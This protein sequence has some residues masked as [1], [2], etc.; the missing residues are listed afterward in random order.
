METIDNSTISAEKQQLN[1][2]LMEK[3][4]PIA[5]IGI[6]LR[7]PGNNLTSDDF[8]Q[9]L[10]NKG[11]GIVDIPVDRWNNKEFYQNSPERG[12]IKTNKGGYLNNITD[13]DAKFFNISPKEAHYIDPQ[14]RIVLESSWEALENANVNIEALKGSDGGV[15]MGVSSIDYSLEVVSLPNDELAAPIGTGTSHS[16]VAGRISYFLGWKGPSVSVDTACSSSLVALHQATQALRR[17]ECSIALCGGVN[18]IHHPRNL[19]IFS[20]ANMLSADGRC[21]TFDDTADGYGRSEGCSVVV[22]KR[23]SDAM[24]DGDHIYATV[25]GSAVNQDGESGGLTVPNGIAQE[26]TMR[27]ALKDAALFPEDIDFVEAHGTGTS[28]GDPIEVNAINNVF[29]QSHSKQ[30][31]LYI[32]SVKGNIG[33]TE[34]AAGIVGVVKA[35]L[36][37]NHA[38]IYSHISMHTPSTHIPWQQYI[39]EVPLESKPMQPKVNRG[40]VNSFGF[41]GTLSSIVLEQAPK[42]RVDNNNQ[43]AADNKQTTQYPTPI[44]CVSAKSK[45][46]LSNQLSRLKNYMENNPTIDLSALA[47][48]TNQRTHFNQRLSYPVNV[49]ALQSPEKNTEVLNWLSKQIEKLAEGKFQESSSPKVAL[50]FTGQGSQY[51]GMGAE[52]YLVSPIFRAA[53]DLCDRMFTPYLQT[54]IKAIMFGEDGE[55]AQKI[56]QTL[57]TQTSLFTFEYAMSRYWFSLGIQPSCVIGHSIGE[58]VAACVAGML[59]LENA[60]KLVANRAML[61][62]SVKAQGGMLAVKATESQLQNYLS[63]FPAL[64]FAAINSPQQCVISGEITQLESLQSALES[65]SIS[66]KKLEVSH[67]FHSQQMEVVY[68]EFYQAI[69]DIPFREAEITLIS[70]LTGDAVTYEQ[71]ADPNYWVRHIGEAVRFADGIKAIEARGKHLCIEVGPSAALSRLGRQTVEGFYWVAST[72]QGSENRITIAKAVADCYQAGL[73]ID[74]QGY[75]H[76]LTYPT[77]N[78]PY[79]A[80]NKQPYW[81]NINPTTRFRNQQQTSQ[82]HPLLG[83]KIVAPDIATPLQMTTTS[84]SSNSLITFKSKISS[85]Q[86][87]YLFDHQVFGQVVFPGAGFVETLIAVEQ[88]LFGE[89]GGD[90]TQ[91]QIHEPLYLTESLIEYTTTCQAQVDGGYQVT[92]HSQLLDEAASNTTIASQND[93]VNHNEQ[94]DSIR[95]LHITATLYPCE[96]QEPHQVKI[97]RGDELVEYSQIKQ[98]NNTLNSI[99]ADDI[100]PEFESIGLNYGDEFQRIIDIQTDKNEIAI[101]QLGYSKNNAT[102]QINE[103]ITPTLL[104]CTM[105]TITTVVKGNKTYLPVAFDKVSFFKKPR[106]LLTSYLKITEFNEHQV[107]ADFVIRDQQRTVACVRGF[108]LQPVS[109]VNT[110][111]SARR[112]LHTVNWKKRSLFSQ[113]EQTEIPAV[114]AINAPQAINQTVLA[115]TQSKWQLI[116]SETIAH[117]ITPTTPPS[118]ILFFW[119]SANTLEENYR[120]LL[121]T[122][123]YLQ[124]D[125]LNKLQFRFWT[126]TQSAQL[127]PEDIQAI[128]ANHTSNDKANSNKLDSLHAA[129]VWGFVHTLINEYPRWQGKVIDMPAEE[130]TDNFITQIDNEII[131]QKTNNDM[132]VAYRQGQRF[133]KKIQEVLVVKNIDEKNFELQITEYGLFENIKPIEVPLEAPQPGEVQIEIRSAGLNFKDVLNALGLLKKYADEH[134][135]EYTPLPLGFEGS[136]VVVQCGANTTFQV[137]DEVML[138]QLGCFKKRLN[139]SQDYVVKKPARLTHA[140]AAGIPTA[141]ITAYYSLH[142]LANIKAGDKVLIHSAA[143]GVGQAAVQIAKAAGAIIYATASPRKWPFLQ[144]QGIEHIFSSRDLNFKQKILELTNNEGVDI[145]LNSLNKDFIPAGLD[146]LGNGGRFV[147]I[148]KLDIWSNDQVKAY[149]DNI[150]YFNF[151]LS[152]LPEQ[153]LNQLN[154][155][156][157]NQVAQQIEAGNYQPLPVNEFALDE[158]QEAF[159]ILS[160]GANTGKLVINLTQ[161]APEATD[162]TINANAY[163]IITGGFGALGQSLA[164]KLIE[165]GAQHIVLCG[166]NLP[167]ESQLSQLRQNWPQHVTLYP[168]KT[169]I[170]DADSVNNLFNLLANDTRP[171]GGVFHTAGVLADAPI[172]GQTLTSIETVF[173]PKITGTD[174]L[175]AALNKYQSDAFFV[176]FSSIAAMLGSMSQANYAAANAYIDYRLAVENAT[177]QRRCLSIN[178]GPWAEIGMAAELTEAQIKGIEEKGIF[179]L[180]PKDGLR[181][182]MRSL[183]S[184]FA[185]LAICEFDWDLQTASSNEVNSYFSDLS[186]GGGSQKKTTINLDEL[187]TANS[188][189]RHDKILE[190]VRASIAGVLH[191]EDIED[192]SRD[193]KIADLGLDSLVAVELK[194]TLEANLRVPLMTS[195]IF[196]YPTIPLL[197]EH[198][199]NELWSDKKPVE[200]NSDIDTVTQL[201]DDELDKELASLME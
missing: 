38:E 118:T 111:T 22:L 108:T 150:D 47:H 166:R 85:Q 164:S 114:I 1:A 32:S 187:T 130:T 176:G 35:A 106:G 122:I 141:Y 6:G 69:K 20:D 58:I 25:R 61:M 194:N 45:A 119:Q 11:D 147:E 10:K 50:L 145:V 196:D 91:V 171:I 189:E 165:R 21:K 65:Q 64:G 107:K 30:N 103:F 73:N 139:I 77:I 120:A 7:L 36:Q 184:Q 87:A 193:A 72:N 70:N 17:K 5:I 67:A 125:S 163:Y 131:L 55:A 117:H 159:A 157:L 181:L 2:L 201:S 98:Q 83:E 151:D 182:L 14:Q 198:L 192:V 129:S 79:Y 134:Q 175:L 124:Q 126:V 110:A 59:S 99:N 197:V 199:L 174:L 92:I 160:R 144:S 169:D 89:N 49:D 95:R 18:V 121:S 188:A 19:M 78:L 33:H 68:D 71:V 94:R 138:S 54:S 105:Q 56:N 167:Q 60:I 3:Y 136:A 177:G 40:L 133:I 52:L 37:L 15:F 75:H 96:E 90:I 178:W 62:Q 170:S 76:G 63:D 4:E 81:L 172:K 113:S 173:A 82:L 161:Q 146:A 200:K 57:F 23:L 29:K 13:F 148:G 190:F 9:F 142:T 84:T 152:E 183:S 27:N 93:Q 180:K 185:Q 43:S 143:G 34:A 46:A 154:K 137:G 51:T 31:P 179:M 48:A 186:F 86:P 16:A 80:F 53:I 109:H 135:I 66:C 128:K 97:N 39:V 191:F 100:Y 41:A 102:Y 158:V 88:E 116:T 156:I 112:F 168:V 162:I 28:L 101:A 44:I 104:D 123:Q 42:K 8:V 26:F 74:W 140:Q 24:Q 195:L 149:H 115:N 153:E 132:F 127:L 155:D 12:K